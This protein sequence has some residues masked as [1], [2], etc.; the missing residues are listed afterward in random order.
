ML[1]KLDPTRWAPKHYYKRILICEFV[2]LFFCLPVFLYFVR[3]VIAPYLLLFF[4]I[5]SRVVCF[6]VV[7]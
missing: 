4:G 3:D 6:T 5:G 1:L 2:F 7:K